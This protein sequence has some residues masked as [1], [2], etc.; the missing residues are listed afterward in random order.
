MRFILA[1]ALSDLSLKDVAAWS[2]VVEQLSS[3]SAE[4]DSFTEKI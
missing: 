4:T 3:P 1:Y 2:A